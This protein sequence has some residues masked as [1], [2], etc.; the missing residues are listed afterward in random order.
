MVQGKLWLDCADRPQIMGNDPVLWELV[1]NSSRRDNRMVASHGVAGRRITK[2]VPQATA[3]VTTNILRCD[4]VAL[5][6]DGGTRVSRVMFGV[7]PNILERDLA[8]R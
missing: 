1:T 7:P 3:E 6:I 2:S 5:F 8:R 4:R